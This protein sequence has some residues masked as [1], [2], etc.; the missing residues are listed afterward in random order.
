M[1]HIID[2]SKRVKLK[3]FFL[4]VKYSVLTLKKGLNHF[5][6]FG[7][8]II[9]VKFLVVSEIKKNTTFPLRGKL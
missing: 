2:E 4:K 8:G 6:W 3:Y 9:D 5:A 1:F 7:K